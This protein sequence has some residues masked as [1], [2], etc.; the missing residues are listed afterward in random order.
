[1]TSTETNNMNETLSVA[2]QT[3]E[4]TTT[5]LTQ[6]SEHEDQ[7]ILSE[8]SA[9]NPQ[10]SIDTAEAISSLKKVEP[11]ASD[12]SFGSLDPNLNEL[13]SATPANHDHE[14][15][16]ILSARVDSDT[17][18]VVSFTTDD[19]ASPADNHTPWEFITSPIAKVVHYKKNLLGFEETSSAQASG[20]STTKLGQTLDKI[21]DKKKKL[22]IKTI[23]MGSAYLPSSTGTPNSESETANTTPM[24]TIQETD[25]NAMQVTMDT[26]TSTGGKTA[27]IGTKNPI[28]INHD[29]QKYRE[30]RHSQRHK[31]QKLRNPAS[32]L[33]ESTRFKSSFE[34]NAKVYKNKK[35]VK[36][37]TNMFY[38]MKTRVEKRETQLNDG[39]TKLKE[40]R[41]QSKFGSS[42][43]KLRN[44]DVVVITGGS[45]GLGAAIVDEF[46]K[47]DV[48]KI[49][50]LD[51]FIPRPSTDLKEQDENS[52][53][54]KGDDKWLF[55]QKKKRI[56]EYIQ[57]DV[58]NPNDV[59]RAKKLIE[60]KQQPK[61]A[62]D[63]TETQEELSA[64][65]TQNKKD[66]QTF[67]PVTVLVNNAAIMRNK[68][69]LLLNDDEID[70]CLRVNLISCF[71]TIKAFLPDM[72]EIQRGFIV[73]VSSVLGHLSPALL[74]TKKITTTFKI[75]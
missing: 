26:K 43:G 59:I 12:E 17:L 47:T 52:T 53:S 13:P 10:T 19:L 37:G 3:S 5:E 21:K 70:Q 36:I 60:S 11:I 62:T 9:T 55:E 29:L 45:R 73:N 38:K 25:K 40:K 66:T 74:S 23:R 6:Q 44:T 33:K 46:V 4:S 27:V 41:R 49:Y 15:S 56:V 18:P 30:L 57:C 58:G 16:S 8:S 31:L 2:Q 54:V 24:P 7:A 69:L 50:V 34:N 75:V 14:S 32:A 61:L 64:N 68:P 72:L 63:T 39:I 65:D 28:K 71:S 51:V 48:A 20:I 67:G 1:M 35:F 22:L 42:F